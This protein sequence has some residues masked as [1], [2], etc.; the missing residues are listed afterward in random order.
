MAT[1]RPLSRRFYGPN[2]ELV[3]S[4]RQTAADSGSHARSAEAPALPPGARLLFRLVV[5]AGRVNARGLVLRAAEPVGS[6]RVG[7]EGVNAEAGGHS[8]RSGCYLV[9]QHRRRAWEFCL[10]ATRTVS[11]FRLD[12][13]EELK[14]FGVR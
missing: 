14:R 9:P 4:L 7:E 5:G 11:L 10:P 12:V 1:A 2:E 3:E 13:E 8:Q 6:G